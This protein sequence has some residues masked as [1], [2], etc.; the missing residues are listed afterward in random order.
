MLK[1]ITLGQYFPGDSF[2]H[3]LDPRIKLILS[4]FYI[5]IIFLCKNVWSFA[6]ILLTTAVF[7]IISKIPF[8]IILKGLKPLIFIIAFTAVINLFFTKGD[9][10]VFEFYFI[11]IYLEG[12]MN[13]ALIIV[14]II[15]LLSGV[16]VILTYTTSPI[17][18]TDALERLLSPLKYLKVPVHD[19]AMMMTIA[20]RFIPTLIEE[21]DKIM[22][23][24]KA[25]GIDFSSGSVIQRAK[26][27]IPVLIPLLVSSFRRASDLAVA[28]EC[29][30]YRGGEG[31]TRMTS[32]KLHARDFVASACFVAICAAVVLIN[33]YVPGFTLGNL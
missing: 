8:K 9:T 2:F 6:L 30:C 29:R 19:F 21:T 11:K 25:R 3:K 14:R 27:L 33:K 15:V 18:L 13:A 12:I 4:L 23:A 5:A 28:M 26:A 17:A 1:D 31:R 22:S 16:S 32:L 20:L 24:Q 10:P 7:I